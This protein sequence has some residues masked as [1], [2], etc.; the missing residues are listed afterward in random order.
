MAKLVVLLYYQL[1]EMQSMNSMTKIERATNLALVGHH[2]QRRNN[3]PYI[4]HPL[5]IAES[6]RK[7]HISEPKQAIRK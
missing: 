5:R 6:G 4:N 7:E 2:K 1:L 3:E